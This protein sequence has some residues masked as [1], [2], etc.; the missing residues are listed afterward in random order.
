MNDLSAKAS[1]NSSIT[2]IN[3]NVITNDFIQIR[4]IFDTL[5]EL[6]FP[7]LVEAAAKTASENVEKYCLRFCE[8][9]KEDEIPKIQ[10]ALE[11]PNSQYLLNST[12]KNAARYGDSID[13]AILAEALRQ[14]LLVEDD[15]L[16]F[17]LEMALDIIP[18]LSK[19]QLEALLISF[20]FHGFGFRSVFPGSVEM[21]TNL[22]FRGFL[23]DSNIKENQLMHMVSLGLF[24]FNQF[25]GGRAIDLIKRRYPDD[26]ELYRRIENGTY[27]TLFKISK[28]Y[29]ENNM[30]HFQPMP[31]ANVIGLLLFKQN[32]PGFD[33][34]MLL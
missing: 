23:P 13:L 24:S 28:Y 27:K 30:I 11:R 16:A 1:G 3:G 9:T 29:D 2:Q 10:K 26:N 25:A 4:A 34:N 21:F 17:E 15:G 8:K 20:Y 7:K 12:L 14:A 6:N 18:R 32:I 19:I 33:M 22:C 31:V 5:F